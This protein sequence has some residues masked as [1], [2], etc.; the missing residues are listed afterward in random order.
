MLIKCWLYPV[1]LADRA[2]YRR[3][4]E[5]KHPG[6]CPRCRQV[7]TGKCEAAEPKPVNSKITTH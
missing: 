7:H 4:L 2:A 1:Q 3:H 5:E 6:P